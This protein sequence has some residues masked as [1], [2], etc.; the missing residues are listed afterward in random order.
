MTAAP[1][2]VHGG[3]GGQ[4]RFARAEAKISHGTWPASKPRS[5]VDQQRW[6]TEIGLTVLNLSDPYAHS[7]STSTPR[8]STDIGALP[9]DHRSR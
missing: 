2:A 3:T 6:G 5:A 1:S 4:L 9:R 8:R 7:R